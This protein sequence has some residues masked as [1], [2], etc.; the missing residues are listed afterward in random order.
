MK[1]TP[2]END[3]DDFKLPTGNFGF[4]ATKVTGELGASE[5]TLA[6]IVLDNSGSVGA[7][8]TELEKVAQETVKACLHS[9]RADNLM[10]RVLSF[11]DRLN[12]VHGFKLLSQC[13]V[14]DY[15]NSLNPGGGTSLFDATQNAVDAEV[16]YSKTLY[17]SDYKANGIVIVVTDGCDNM[18]TQTAN[19]VKL[20]LEAAVKSESLESLVTILVGVNITDSGVKDALDKFQKEAGFTSFVALADA[21][22]STLAKL[23]KF[24]SRSI[25]SQSK[26]LGSGA[27]AP[28]QSLT[29]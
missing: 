17:D 29:F 13:N 7:F 27:A 14:G 24:V 25:S 3:L 10:L 8:K 23:A 4:S 16:A 9:P 12:E 15:D 22:K 18:S 6:T 1:S 20:A 5:Y 2:Q 21:S 28:A 11:N 26:S 19:T